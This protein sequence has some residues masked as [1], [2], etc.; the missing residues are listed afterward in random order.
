MENF[1]IFID[2]MIEHIVQWRGNFSKCIPQ[3]FTGNVCG[4]GYECFLSHFALLFC[5]TIV[6]R[7]CANYT[8]TICKRVRPLYGT[9]TFDNIDSPSQSTL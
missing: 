7:Y 1:S 8:G 5:L 4:K 6:S 2:L 9:I 3:E